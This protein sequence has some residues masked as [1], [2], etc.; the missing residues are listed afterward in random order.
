MKRMK[1][2]K[3]IEKRCGGV[4]TDGGLRY[5]NPPCLGTHRNGE[6]SCYFMIFMVK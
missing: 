6:V 3:H 4:S 5:A 1:D 2:M